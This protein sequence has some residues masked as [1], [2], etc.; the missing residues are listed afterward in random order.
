MTEVSSN[1][2]ST[3]CE[4]IVLKKAGLLAHVE[5][6]E[7]FEISPMSKAGNI[8]TKNKCF[9]HAQNKIQ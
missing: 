4:S 8:R 2:L 7:Y 3:L 1:V 5:Q 9:V 6:N